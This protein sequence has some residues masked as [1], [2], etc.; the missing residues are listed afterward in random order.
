[1]TQN[2]R[3]PSPSTL[4]T[5]FA[6]LT[7][8]PWHLHRTLKSDNPLELNGTLTGTA[9]FT[10]LTPSTETDKPDT[11]PSFTFQDRDIQY[12]EEGEMPTPPGVPGMVGL[13]FTKK[14]IWRMS[15]G[16]AMSVWFAKVGREVEADYLFHEFVF[17]GSGEKGENEG[18]NGG[19]EGYVDAP[20]PPFVKGE[21]EVLVARGN[22]LCIND[23]YRTAYAFRVGGSG[24]VVSWASRHVVKGPK[25]NQDIV[26]L[27]W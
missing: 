12:H 6:T 19:G 23:M 22:H 3:P 20:D 2:M 18:E 14:Y 4:S 15:E 11:G 24:E 13:R 1:M 9:S 8:H 27:Y 10:S 25:K 17:G 7:R 16:G 26:N 21:T 5:L